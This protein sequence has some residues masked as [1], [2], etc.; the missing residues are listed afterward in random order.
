MRFLIIAFF[1]SIGLFANEYK[2]IEIIPANTNYMEES[3]EEFAEILYD[4]VVNA[5]AEYNFTKKSS[6]SMYQL[7]GLLLAK[8]QYAEDIKLIHRK[9]VNN[10]ISFM[11][12]RALDKLLIMDFNTT[13]VVPIIKNCTG[14]CDIN[15]TFT[16]YS[17][18][19]EPNSSTFTYV[20]DGNS[21]LLS[22][23]SSYSI[24]QLIEKFLN[25]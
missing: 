21:C 6:N 5:I 22:D 13:N 7:Q 25:K 20:F 1:L 11:K 9:V 10:P 23:K 16:K 18:N 24:T 14:L 15:I 2:K 3:A 17:I 4:N 8:K 12:K 19:T